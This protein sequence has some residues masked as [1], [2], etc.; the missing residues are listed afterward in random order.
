M[1]WEPVIRQSGEGEKILFKIGLMTF[2]VSSAQTNGHFMI[3][4]TELPPKASVEPHHH[5]EAEVFYILSGQFIFYVS[6]M[7]R[8]TPCGPGAFVCVP[9]HV[10]HA[11]A[12]SGDSSG[13]IL[14]L[15]MPGGSDGLESFFRQ[16]GVPVVW[17]KD[18]P[19]LNQPVE[20]LQAVIA[21]RKGGNRPES[22]PASG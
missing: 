8:P 14:G 4:E 18:V 19:D 5:P 13:R 12:N 3:S 15:M 1:S 17:D 16:V 21:E 22:V 9:P 20:H 10:L 6:D 7:N 11:F 2:K